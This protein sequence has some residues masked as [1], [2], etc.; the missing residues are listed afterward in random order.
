MRG[1]SQLNLLPLCT[2]IT[3]YTRSVPSDGARFH[4]GPWG[5]KP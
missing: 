1:A 4:D 5:S 3:G 2:I